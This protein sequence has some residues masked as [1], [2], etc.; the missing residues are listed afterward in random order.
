MVAF[1]GLYSR[2]RLVANEPARRRIGSPL[3][4]EG[5]VDYVATGARTKEDAKQYGAREAD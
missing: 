5:F 4:I 3:M 1:T 2:L